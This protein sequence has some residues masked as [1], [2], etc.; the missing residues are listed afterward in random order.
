[1]PDGGVCVGVAGD[2]ILVVFSGNISARFASIS[3][4]EGFKLLGEFKS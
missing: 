3:S 2:H 1:M 4:A